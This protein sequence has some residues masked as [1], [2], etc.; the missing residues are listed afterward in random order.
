MKAIFFDR[1]G[2]LIKNKHYLKNPEQ[3]EL[4]DQFVPEVLQELLNRDYLIFLHTNQSGIE[5]GMF[6]LEIVHQCN[7]RMF[8]LIGFNPFEEICIAPNIHYQQSNY[9]KPSTKFIEE[10]HGKYNFTKA[11]TFYVGDSKCDLETA[12]NYNIGAIGLNIETNKLNLE[13]SFGYPIVET[14]KEILHYAK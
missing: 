12:Y 4:I 11:N 10:M 5:R 13:N 8:S 3:V 14:F 7:D 6:N 9:R 2:T 1:D